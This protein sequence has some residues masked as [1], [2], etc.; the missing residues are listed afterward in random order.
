MMLILLQQVLTFLNDEGGL[1]FINGAP[2]KDEPPCGFDGTK[3]PEDV[4]PFSKGEDI[5]FSLSFTKLLT[6]I[7]F[8]HHL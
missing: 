3:C 6:G 8:Y 7:T 4:G 1:Q 5:Y 2:P